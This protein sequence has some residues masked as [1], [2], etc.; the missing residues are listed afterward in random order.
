MSRIARIVVEGVPYH[1]TQRGNGRQQVFFDAADYQLYLDLLQRNATDAGLVI[2]G[3]CLMPNH[4]HVVAVPH[5]PHAMASALGRTHADYARHFNL[6]KRACGHVWQARYYSCPLEAA[7]LWQALAYVE[8]NPVRAGIVEQ[9]EHY[10]WSSA[11]ARLAED[12]SQLELTSW[13]TEYTAERWR[14]VLATSVAEEAFGQR[15]QEASR[16]GRPLGGPDFA[17]QLENVT[18]RTLRPRRVG[19]PRASQEQGQLTLKIGA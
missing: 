6:R 4:V 12:S 7:H 16:R 1:I 14:Q 13:R 9:A 10:V 17:Q 15:L 18:G 3:W 2:W 19:R 5:R 11:R 8:R